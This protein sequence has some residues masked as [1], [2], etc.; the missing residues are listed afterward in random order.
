MCKHNIAVRSR[1]YCCRGEA[2]IIADFECVSVALEFQHTMRMHR[3][4]VLP[5]ALA[6]QYFPHFLIKG[7]TFGNSLLN[8]KY[9]F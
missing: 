4:I 7:M 3:I 2:I 6:L 9:V 8:M 5:V 1:R